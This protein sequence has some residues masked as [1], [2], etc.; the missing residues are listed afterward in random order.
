MG[1]ISS[2]DANGM[3]FSSVHSRDQV[4]RRTDRNIRR[5]ARELV[6]FILQIGGSCDLEQ[7]GRE[8]QLGPGDLA[9]FD[10]T[11][12]Y[13]LNLSGEFRQLVIQV[14][15]AAVR[16]EIGPSSRFVS[17]T[18]GALTPMGKLVVPFLQHAA[19][20]LGHLR[21]S[22]RRGV[23][24]ATKALLTAAFG[25]LASGDAAA[26]RMGRDAILCRAKAHIE[27]SLHDPN[28]TVATVAQALGVSHRYLQELFQ[29]EGLTPNGYLWKRR[30]ERS[31]RQLQNEH[32]R[33]ES[34]SQI[35]LSCGFKDFTHFSRRFRFAYQAS[36]RD[37]RAAIGRAGA[38]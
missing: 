27:E 37:F 36:P 31:R 9:C 22:E 34:I 13:R 10:T 11:R 30:L 25:G 20:T 38:A 29:G 33:G 19:G 5:D 26:T 6:L 24:D 16:E 1:E 21:P 3:V 23:S 14:P 17:R 8:A 4:V 2:V 12:P 7:D 28:L 35:A 15:K 18:L 32:L